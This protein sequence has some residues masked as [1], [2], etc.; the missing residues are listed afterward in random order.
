MPRLLSAV[1]IKTS[2]LEVA[3]TGKLVFHA[4]Y[5]QVWD[6]YQHIGFWLHH[7]PS[8]SCGAAGILLHLLLGNTGVIVV[9]FKWCRLKSRKGS[10]LWSDKHKKVDFQLIS[11]EFLIDPV[12]ILLEQR[13]LPFFFH[14]SFSCCHG[15]KVSHSGNFNSDRSGR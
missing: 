13:G 11:K 4:V 14:L 3:G 7:F 6:Y 8:I 15:H 5:V 12:K 1:S 10:V 9:A 2:W